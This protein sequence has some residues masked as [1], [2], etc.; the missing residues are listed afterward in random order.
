MAD[1]QNSSGKRLK[2]TALPTIFTASGTAGAA[3]SCQPGSG[4]WVVE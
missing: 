1:L 4:V 2:V 3:V